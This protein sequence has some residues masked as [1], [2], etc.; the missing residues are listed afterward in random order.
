MADEI[1][2]IAAE[3]ASGA[4]TP[5]AIAHLTATSASPGVGVP[6]AA[7]RVSTFPVPVQEPVHQ[8]TVTAGQPFLQMTDPVRATGTMRLWILLA[9]GAAN[10]T[11]SLSLDG[12]QT[13]GTLNGG[14]AL[15]AGQWVAVAWPVHPGDVVAL[16]ADTATTVAYAA[17]DYVPST[18]G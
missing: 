15:T 16:R 5:P 7:V 18:L 13:W 17:C 8:V 11:L 12:G 4:R 2:A 10:S 9:A 3:P 6:P 14:T 1:L